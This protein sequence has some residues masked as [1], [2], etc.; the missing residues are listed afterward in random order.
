MALFLEAQDGEKV[1]DFFLIRER[2]FRQASNGS[3]YA[4]LLLERNLELVP[5]QLWD[6]T[7]EQKEQLQP[8]VLIKGEGVVVT[9]KQKKLLKLSRVRLVTPE[10]DVLV[11]ELISRR[12][13]SREDLWQELRMMMEEITSPIL[14]TIMKQLFSRRQVRERITT[15]PASKMYHHAYYAGL[16][17][18]IVQLA[19]AAYQLLPL[20]P[21]V[22]RDLVLTACMLSDIGKTK[23]LR[24]VVAPDYTTSGELMGHLVLGIE[25][26][27][28]AAREAGISENDVEVIALKHLLLSQNGEVE[29]GYG[30]A[31]SEKTAE[32]IL[33]A[34]LKQ[35]N[36]KLHA[37][38]MLHERT[39][40]EW[41]YSPLFKRKMFHPK[42]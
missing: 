20:Y 8:K 1:T 11:S 3:E 9:Y 10:D 24:D 26:I 42:S 40:E 12:G 35:L 6:L 21:Y 28:D 19:Q 17:H 34:S 38:E 13:I 37:I 29:T 31:V 15:L 25:M 33:F 30:S 5:A 32:A 39:E 41:V 2:E 22:N 4:T 23:A 27:N 16:L 7:L 14:R 36:T 18:Q